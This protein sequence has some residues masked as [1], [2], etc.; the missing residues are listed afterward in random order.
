MMHGVRQD[1]AGTHLILEPAQIFILAGSESRYDR[2]PMTYETTDAWGIWSIVDGGVRLQATKRRP[3]R[4][5]A[6]ALLVLQPGGGCTMDI[7]PATG[8][9]RLVFTVRWQPRDHL[10]TDHFPCAQREG[11]QPTDREWFGRDLPVLVD[12]P[13][14]R[15]GMALV[16]RCCREW[17]RGQHLRRLRAGAEL[18]VWLYDW[19][20]SLEEET[21]DGDWSRLER[22]ARERLAQG[23]T[24][25]HLAK[26]LGV[27]RSTLY[28]R[29]RQA[30]LP[31]P[32][33][34]LASLRQDE[35]R[36]LLADGFSISDA[37]H[38]CGF[39]S[40]T[41]FSRWF[42]RRTGNVPSRFGSRFP[43]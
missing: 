23:I 33:E 10:D 8:F 26:E 2:E 9:H 20:L 42:R 6:P 24:V 31:R 27:D 16:Q 29:F 14:R 17:W 12:D 21:A 43:T 34:W 41:A 22:L 25:G 5:I 15:P 19:L 7:P 28:R 4:I 37:A 40:P 1:P 39:R 38:L 35:A 11:R 36:R 32:K 13:H 18:A 30:G 3:L